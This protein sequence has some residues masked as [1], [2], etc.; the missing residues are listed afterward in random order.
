MKVYLVL[1]DF[2]LT[3]YQSLKNIRKLFQFP[4]QPSSMTVHRCNS[5]R[6]RSRK[7]TLY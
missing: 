5:T 4:V 6:F 7:N 3:G 2:S 1:T